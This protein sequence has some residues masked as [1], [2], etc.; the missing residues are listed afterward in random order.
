MLKRQ[1]QSPKMINEQVQRKLA[2]NGIHKD[3][4]S[5]NIQVNI[6]LYFP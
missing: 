3:D 5:K 2:E 6:L 4:L 1:G